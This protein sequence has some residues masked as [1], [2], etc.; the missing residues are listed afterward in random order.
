MK[1]FLANLRRAAHDSKPTTIGGGQFSPAECQ[2]V[3]MTIKAMQN[4]LVEL[5]DIDCL[6]PENRPE[7]RGKARSVLAKVRAS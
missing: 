1:T 5:I 4:A 6:L 7:A 2:Q 3:L